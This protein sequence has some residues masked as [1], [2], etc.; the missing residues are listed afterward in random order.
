[1]L[2]ERIFEQQGRSKQII[3]DA[4]LRETKV[5]LII[6]LAVAE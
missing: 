6:A 1:M 4:A 5:H 2:L 3:P